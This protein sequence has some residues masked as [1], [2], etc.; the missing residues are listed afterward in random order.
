LKVV[1]VLK[2][3]KTGFV[4]YGN[5]KYTCVT[6]KKNGKKKEILKDL[7]FS[8]WN[9]TYNLQNVLILKSYQD[10]KIKS[11]WISHHFSSKRITKIKNLKTSLKALERKVLNFFLEIRK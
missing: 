3:S 8:N 11:K 10:L 9:Q 5:N 1:I 2:I 4:R 6:T 7:E